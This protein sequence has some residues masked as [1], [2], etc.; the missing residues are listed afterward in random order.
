[1]HCVVGNVMGITFSF[2]ILQIDVLNHQN[3]HRPLH[4]S[5]HCWNLGG[6]YEVLG[7][8]LVQEDQHLVHQAEKEAVH[9]LEDHQ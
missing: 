2:S 8:G 6:W 1:M 5:H 3:P 9:L 7:V 4:Q